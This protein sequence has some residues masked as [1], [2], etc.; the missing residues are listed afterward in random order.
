MLNEVHPASQADSNSVAADGKLYKIKI[1][2]NLNLR[3]SLV[4]NVTMG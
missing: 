3:C 2:L 4:S 1:I